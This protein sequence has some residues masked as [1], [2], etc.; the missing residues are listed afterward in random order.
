MLAVVALRGGGAGGG[1]SGGAGGG[2]QKKKKFAKKKKFDRI[3]VSEL[4]GVLHRQ[5]NQLCTAYKIL[6]HMLVYTGSI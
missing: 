5:S 4:A 2:W 3:G 6:A 1:G